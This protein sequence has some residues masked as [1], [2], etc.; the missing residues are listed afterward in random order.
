MKNNLLPVDI[1]I[2]RNEKFFA[3]IQWFLYKHFNKKELFLVGKLKRINICGVLSQLM[4]NIVIIVKKIK[5]KL[6]VNVVIN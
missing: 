2:R 5:Q 1:Y 3:K 4:K 6:D